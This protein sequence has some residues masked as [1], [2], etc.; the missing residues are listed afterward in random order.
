M[1]NRLTAAAES[2]APQAGDILEKMHPDH[3][4]GR[5]DFE[6]FRDRQIIGGF[7]RQNDTGGGIGRVAVLVR[8]DA[9]VKRPYLLWPIASF[10]QVFAILGIG[11]WKARPYLLQFVGRD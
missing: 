7:G 4:F 9:Q 3:K 2:R 8:S 6:P 11:I 5:P 10:S 1:R